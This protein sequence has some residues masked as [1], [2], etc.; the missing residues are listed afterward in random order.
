[1]VADRLS[2]IIHQKKHFLLAY[3]T[4]LDGVY[5]LHTFSK[6]ITRNDNVVTTVHQV[7]IFQ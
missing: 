5:S 2:F 7:M 3:V 4:D 1:M 6:H